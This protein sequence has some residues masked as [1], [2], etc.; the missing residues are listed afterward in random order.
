MRSHKEIGR[1][2]LFG[3]SRLSG[4]FSL[5]RLFG[6]SSLYGSPGLSGL[7][8]SLGLLCYKRLSISP[9]LILAAY[10]L[11]PTSS[12]FLFTPYFLP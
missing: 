10:C 12:C 4:L 6:L 11:L 8:S 5:S 9:P 7:L 3:V 2:R 1:L